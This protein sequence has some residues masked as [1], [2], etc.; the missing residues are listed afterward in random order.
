MSVVFRETRRLLSSAIAIVLGVAFVAATLLLGDALNASMRDAAAGPVGAASV[1]VTGENYQRVPQSAIATIEALPGVTAVRPV[2]STYA[3]ISVDG[4]RDGYVLTNTP[5]LS[6]RT[7]L[8]A[9]RLPQASGEVAA[10]SVAADGRGVRL[11]DRLP[12]TD[13]AHGPTSLTVVGIVQAGRDATTQTGMPTLFAPIDDVVAWDGGGGFTAVY[14]T[15]AVQPAVAALAVTAALA[16]G[17]PAMTVQTA[18]A[19]TAEAIANMTG[20]TTLLLTVLLTFAVIALFVSALVISNTF[21]ILVAQRTR[22][23]ALLRCVGATR[24]QVFASVVGEALALGVVASLAGL[25]LGYGLAWVAAAASAGTGLELATAVP[26]PTSLAVPLVA[27]LVL[28]LVAAV[29]PARRATRI[30]PLAALRAGALVPAAPVGRLTVGLGVLMTVV[31][32]AALAAGSFFG[33]PGPGQAG[34]GSTNLLVGIAG[35]LVS[36]A[37]V[38]MLSGVVVPF[39]ARLLGRVAGRLGGVPGALAAENAVRNP[40]RAAASASALLV[41]VTLITMMSVGAASG[42]ASV[43]AQLNGHYP[44]DAL[45][46]PGGEPLSAAA[47]AAARGVRG[48][49]GGELVSTEY[50]QVVGAGAT[51]EGSVWGVDAADIALLRNTGLAAGLA[52]DTIVV[53][54]GSGLTT[55]A[56][57]DLR[58]SDAAPVRLRAVEARL[59]DAPVLVTAATLARVVP[60]A[61]SMMWV[62]FADDADAVA[63]STELGKAIATVTPGADVSTGAIVRQEIEQQIDVVLAVVVG[64]LTVAVVIALV[65]IGNTLGLSVLE[66]TQESGLLRALGLT[67]AGLRRMIGIEAV[68][69]AGVAVVLGL[70]LGLVYGVAGAYALLG[71]EMTIVLEVPWARLALV[72]AVAL[73]AGWAASVVP[74]ARAS[75]VSPVAA[76]AEE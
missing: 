18:E 57:V 62:R 65:G 72:A 15:S 35:G 23:L 14:V 50:L 59:S 67:R 75:R 9:G 19:Y 41:G 24:R 48:V 4:R 27:G 37:G 39:V 55:G 73:L 43:V 30:P 56:E 68:L 52:D 40:R 36:F 17:T 16:G 3:Q 54:L 29:V 10:S 60:E 7:R 42:Q 32:G 63:T 53:P 66:R 76:L 28:T 31:G 6:D 12:L 64:L 61:R 34:G 5:P 1:V 49:V 47:L 8:L 46:S 69:L 2:I 20:S 26:T 74:S 45:V 25:A 51:L 58:G 70:C 71:R 22:Q 33:V 11:G 44:V 21:A 38:L 13:A